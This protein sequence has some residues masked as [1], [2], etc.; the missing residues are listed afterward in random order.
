MTGDRGTKTLQMP[1]YG[2]AIT[3]SDPAVEMKNNIFYTTKEPGSGGVNAKNYA[4]GMATTT[5]ANL[6]S[7]YN[8]YWSTG[9]LDGGFRTGSLAAAGGTDYATL[10]LYATAIS[11][12][13][14]SQEADPLFKMFL[15]IFIPV[16]YKTW[17]H[18]LPVLPMIMIARSGA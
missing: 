16:R 4:V 13:V 9:T 18:P 12:D 15:M 5:F 1:G 2:I 10:G 11:D 7:N 14:N 6:N 17:E 8:N 3:G